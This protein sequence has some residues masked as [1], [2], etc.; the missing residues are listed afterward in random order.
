MHIIQT[1]FF[2][3]LITHIFY[4]F[5]RKKKFT[6]R[7]AVAPLDNSAALFYNPSSRAITIIPC[8]GGGAGGGG[9]RGPRLRG[10]T[11]RCPKTTSREPD[12][13]QAPPAQAAVAARRAAAGVVDAA[14]PVDAVAAAAGP[15][16][17]VR[18]KLRAS[19]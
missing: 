2:N 14:A 5:I 13:A 12:V 1:F 11:S 18:R 19:S 9:G 4:Y 17:A 8:N 6:S 10:L 15:L 16:L 3:K 7:V